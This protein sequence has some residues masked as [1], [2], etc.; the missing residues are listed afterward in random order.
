M[1]FVCRNYLEKRPQ[2]QDGESESPVTQNTTAWQ[3]C[4]CNLKGRVQGSHPSSTEGQPK[5]H[6][7]L[8]QDSVWNYFPGQTSSMKLIHSLLL[9]TGHHRTLVLKAHFR[10]QDSTLEQ[11]NPRV[12]HLPSITRGLQVTDTF[13]GRGSI[14]PT[15]LTLFGWPEQCK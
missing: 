14:H 11:M 2:N 6:L 4:C 1:L 3:G 9:G 12:K 13:S 7:P 15:V 8:T 5:A 10:G